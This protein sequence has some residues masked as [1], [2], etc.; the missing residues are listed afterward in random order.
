MIEP[1]TIAPQHYERIHGVK[2]HFHGVLTYDRALVETDPGKFIQVLHGN[3]RVLPEMRRVHEKTKDIAMIL[4]AKAFAPGHRLRHE[5][6]RWLANSPF[7]DRVDLYG[8]GVG[9]PI[10]RKDLVL[11]D[12]RYA[13]EIE[14]GSLDYYFTEKLIDCMM[15]GVIPIY[16]GCPSIGNFFDPGAIVPFATLTDLERA[17]TEATV[18]RWEAARPAIERN[19]TIAQ[20]F[21]NVHQWM[22]KHVFSKIRRP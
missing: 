19:F 10:E 9:N 16:W 14:N 22:D 6:V 18:E 3:T 1:R 17:L 20:N 13:I 15:V 8:A 5:V 11:A 4:S 21:V 7:R 12:Y 2:Q